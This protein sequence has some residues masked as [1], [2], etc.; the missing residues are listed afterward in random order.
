MN[1]AYMQSLQTSHHFPADLTYR[2]FPSEL[3][4]LIDDLYESTQLP[5]E[6]I[7]NTVLATLSLSCQ[8]LVD[9]VHPHTNMPEPC[10]LYLLAI[11]EPG[12][13][14]TTINR[15]VMNPCY[16][17]ADRLIQQYEERNKDYKTELQI[18][19]TR[20]KA[21]AANLRKAVNRGYPGEQEEEALRNH[22]RNKPTRPVRPNFIYEDV[23]LKALV[24]GLNE[25]PEAG[26]ISD[27]AVTFFRSYL[28]NY[29]GLLN[30]AWSGQ[31]FDFGRADEKY[32]ITPRLTFSLMS[33]PD[34]FTNYI[35]KN[36]VLA[37]G[38]G[39]LS[40]FL[41]SQ[42][43]SPSRVRDYTRGEFRT[44]PTLEKFHKKI[45]GFLLSHNINSP[46]MSTE[47]KT[48]KLA[49]KALGSGRK[50]R[51]RLKEKRLQEGSGNTSE[52]LF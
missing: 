11:A 5:L 17:F 26:V 40:R 13:G 21:L 33:Q 14:K 20:Q 22:E 37:W 16:E 6:L 27:E 24:E 3:A 8:S 32:H 4:Y 29:P 36:D 44:K 1:S 12:A 18:W 38:S 50:T 51:L 45:N 25:H 34:V 41:F 28:K 19:N 2:L 52:I 10:S 47:R 30:K 49:K 48:L 15:L 9:V 23:S 31:P 39:F 42:T 7:F 43:G 46:G 35:N